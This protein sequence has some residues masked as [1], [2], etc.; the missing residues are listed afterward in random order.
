VIAGQAPVPAGT[1]QV[2]P[3]GAALVRLP[4]LPET[5]RAKTFAVSLEPEWGS[6]APTGPIVLLGNAN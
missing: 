5:A 3:W 2:D 6:A 4:A 1:F